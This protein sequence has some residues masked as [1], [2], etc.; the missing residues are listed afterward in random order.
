MIRKAATE[1]HFVNSKN[2]LP[3]VEVHAD[4]MEEAGF[5]LSQ[6]V[7]DILARFAAKNPEVRATVNLYGSVSVNFHESA[8]SEFLGVAGSMK[9]LEA[10]GAGFSRL[11]GVKS[12][13]SDYIPS[14]SGI[15]AF[16]I[17]DGLLWE[18]ED[19]LTWYSNAPAVGDGVEAAG[20]AD[21][22]LDELDDDWDD[23]SPEE[24]AV[25]E[26]EG[27]DEVVTRI[28]RKAARYRAARS[29]AKVGRIRQEIERVFGLPE[30]S[31]ALRGPDGRPLRS[32]AMISTL[33]RRWEEA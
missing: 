33:R 27:D 11:P 8:W 7:S 23:D 32:D 28:V 25:L 12:R 13:Y 15:R 14:A 3:T 6:K 16:H 24:E 18:P 5:D 30:G 29:D 10:L 1:L 31:V 19:A 9:V 2:P 22:P 17:E 21:D 4:S 20:A 26:S